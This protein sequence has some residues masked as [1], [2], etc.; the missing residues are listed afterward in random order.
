MKP[1]NINDVADYVI[2]N[3]KGEDPSA[4]LINLKLQKL[5]YYVQAWSLGIS[6]EPFFVGKFQAWIHGPVSRELY[7]RFK[8]VKGLYSEINLCDMKNSA[9]EFP[10]EDRDVNF[11]NFILHN[12]AKLSGTQLEQL[13]HQEDPWKITRVGFLPF[14]KC[15][16]EIDEDLMRAYYG[17]KWKSISGK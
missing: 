11:L 10:F 4:S 1:Y 5:V 17:N 15:E 14:Q 6:G 3:I 8:L 2:Y 12:Y 16:K 9:T 13:T 7:D